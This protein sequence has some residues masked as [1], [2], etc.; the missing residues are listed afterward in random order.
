MAHDLDESH[1]GVEQTATTRRKTSAMGTLA[2]GF[3]A[4]DVV[5]S[6][7]ETGQEYEP[8]SSSTTFASKDLLA[9][10]RPGEHWEGIHRYDEK[11]TWE[12]SEERHLIRKVSWED[13][14]HVCCN[15][16]H[17]ARSIGASAP[18]HVSCSLH[19]S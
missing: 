12:S 18:S 3:N 6:R 8:H 5:N 4:L 13:I 2:G 7:R 16:L 11:F 9:Y 17:I 1:K 14:L 19:Y 10:Y 15:R